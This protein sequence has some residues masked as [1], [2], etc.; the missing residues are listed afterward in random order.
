LRAT[1]L[2]SKLFRGPADQYHAAR[3]LREKIVEAEDSAG[4]QNSLLIGDFNMNPFEEGMNAADGLHGVMDKQIAE[5]M[6]RRFQRKKKW[7]F[8][9]QIAADLLH[10][11]SRRSRAKAG[12]ALDQ[13]HF[14]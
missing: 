10:R 2:A 11:A 1:F 14:G 8:F 3:S 12:C 4:H 13:S 5:R 6:S 7:D 9:S